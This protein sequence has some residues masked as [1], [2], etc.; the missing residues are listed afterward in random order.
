MAVTHSGTAMPTLDH[1][2]IISP[3]WPNVLRMS[4]PASMIS[5]ASVQIIHLR[6]LLQG[7]TRGAAF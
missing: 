1:L 5:G 6:R 4:A 7:T 2:T 3:H